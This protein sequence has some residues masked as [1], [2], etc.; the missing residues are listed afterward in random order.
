V[1]PPPGP[2]YV[3]TVVEVA[4]RDPSIARVLREICA[5]DGAVRATA[6]D[7]VAAHLGSH[8]DR[9]EV[10]DCVAALR[11]DDVARQIAEALATDDMGGSGRP[12][13]PPALGAP[14]HSDGAPR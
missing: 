1:Q 11:R 14:P 6:L 4:R 10:L 2:A 5:L 9:R 8:P 3:A 7:L 12:P 13:S